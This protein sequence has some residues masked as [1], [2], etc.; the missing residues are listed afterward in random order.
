ML[1]WTDKEPL[2]MT[3]T[4]GGTPLPGNGNVRVFTGG[5][6]S[7]AGQN[8]TP[9]EAAR[10]ADEMAARINEA[11][12]KRKMVEYRVIY[13][14]YKAVDGVRLPTRIQRMTDGLATEEMTLEKIKVNGKIDAS[15]FAVAKSEK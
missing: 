14:D 15:I 4:S 5:S 12:A 2:R 7:V 6:G 13:A 10:M 1:M 11:E 8:V 3:A 9:E